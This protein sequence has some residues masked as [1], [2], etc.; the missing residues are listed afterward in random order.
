MAVRIRLKR[1]GRRHRP[2]YRLCAMDAR[3]PRDGR[4]IEELGTYDPLQRDETRRVVL[5]KD[6]VRHWL[7]VGAQL[8]ETAHSLLKNQ[9]IDVSRDRIK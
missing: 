9:G 1:M 5:N 4:A 6:R 3:T 2:F 7:S 8:T